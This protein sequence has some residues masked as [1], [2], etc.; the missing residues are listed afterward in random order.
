[1]STY[2]L[3]IKTPFQI[4][5]LKIKVIVTPNLQNQTPSYPALS[6]EMKGQNMV[7]IEGVNITINPTL[8]LITTIK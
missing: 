4:P 7:A 6:Y 2:N 1:M 5:Y 3:I 8:S